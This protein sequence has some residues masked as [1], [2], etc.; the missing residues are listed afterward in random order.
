MHTPCCTCHTL[1]LSSLYIFSLGVAQSQGWVDDLSRGSLYLL[2]LPP[3][4]RSTGWKQ[5]WPPSPNIPGSGLESAEL[6]L[7]GLRELSLYKLLMG[8]GG[9]CGEGGR[10]GLR[11]T[12]EGGVHLL[13][14]YPGQG[15]SLPDIPRG[16]S[17][18]CYV[19][20]WGYPSDKDC[21]SLG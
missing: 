10:T 16:S 19:V 9:D 21:V 18:G 3:I 12:R 20:G 14:C 11:K 13:Q 2:R 5:R 7:S 15:T 8:R 6:W 17:R 4:W 1:F